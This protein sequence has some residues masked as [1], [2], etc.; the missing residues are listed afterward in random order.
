M[1]TKTD[2]RLYIEE[3]GK[4]P[5]DC[6]L[7]HIAWFTVED[8]QYDAVKI[9]DDFDR[10]GL[11]PKWL[12]PAI[13]PTDAF[14]KASSEIGGFE[15]AVVGGNTA[16]VLVRDV[17]KSKDVIIRHIVR[18][19]VDA[20]NVQLLYEEVGE[21]AFYKPAVRGGRVDL[22]SARY[23]VT[24]SQSLVQEEKD[25]LN[26]LISQ[27]GY[28]YSRYADYHDGQ[29]I[30]GVVRNYLLYL[31]GIAMKASVY[32]VH[33]SRASELERLQEF[34]NGLSKGATSLTLLPLADLPSLRTEVVDAFQREAEKELQHLAEEIAKV[35]ATRKGPISTSKY[36]QMRDEYNRVM[37]KAT[38]YTRT[39]QISQDR[40]AGAAE[41]VVDLL[42][43]LQSDF[44]KQLDS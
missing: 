25:I 19:V 36:A 33:S 38:E 2:F 12:P 15:Y 28:A 23:R 4:L 22:S 3:N 34:V 8:G 35:R 44:A 14:L 42:T 29:K 26:T 30:R 21:I 24:L 27:F 37:A 1:T 41:T 10:L 5:A 31:N 7:G 6:V 13:S 9:S 18:E 43:E 39:L 40:T 20:K 32:F 11:N 17:I 16:R